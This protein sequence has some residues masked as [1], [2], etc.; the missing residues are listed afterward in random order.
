METFEGMKAVGRTAINSFF[1]SL[2]SIRENQDNYYFNGVDAYFDGFYD[3][4][5]D[6]DTFWGT[7]FLAKAA[8]VARHRFGWR[9]GSC[10]VAAYLNGAE[11]ESFCDFPTYNKFHNKKE[12]FAN[13]FGRPDDVSL[14]L[15]L[16]KKIGGKPSHAFVKGAAQYLSRLSLQSLLKYKMPKKEYNMFDL[17]N[18]S[19]AKSDAIGYYKNHPN[20]TANTWEV[21]VSAA[22][23]PQDKARAWYELV[24]TDSLGILALLRNLRNIWNAFNIVD[25]R[26]VLNLD[27]WYHTDH[28]LR[29]A[30]WA[31]FIKPKITDASNR[32]KY[33]V[34]PHQWYSAIKA[35]YAIPSYALDIDDNSTYMD[36]LETL[37]VQF[38]ESVWNP[39]AKM[40]GRNLVVIDVS[41]SMEGS[42][43]T[44][45][46]T[47]NFA[48]QGFIAA[49]SILASNRGNTDCI[50]FGTNA[51]WLD[52]EAYE[53]SCDGIYDA[54]EHI[55]GQWLYQHPLG[56]G[57]D[58]SK[59]FDLVDSKYDRIFLFSDMQVMNDGALWSWQKRGAK[60]SFQELQ[61]KFGK[62]HLYSYDLAGYDR[63]P[64]DMA[65]NIQCLTAF[66]PKIFEA[67]K[68][69]EQGDERVYDYIMQQ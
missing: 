4:I 63:D 64:F 40:D 56:C 54:L 44:A 27:G 51:A 32:G 39:L 43:N 17:I 33:P 30:I 2:M 66:D 15:S 69:F 37:K 46:S 41:G 6:I 11:N 59:A 12:F 52:W 61:D 13:F 25:L 49:A 21:K 19:H 53:E 58:I 38:D 3:S 23:T 1:N 10:I 9:Y 7:R 5:R 60:T 34:Y 31:E 24:S 28:E 50:M 68:L 22:K 29:H 67:V 14:I 36:I 62:M 65:D 48:E 18:I 47:L 57:T 45:Y 35:A 26:F 16:I 20:A 8:Y 55:K 42:K